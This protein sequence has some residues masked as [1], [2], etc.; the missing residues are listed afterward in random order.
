MTG[1][2]LDYVRGVI[3]SEGF[4][5]A[6]IHYSNFEKVEDPEFHEKRRAFVEAHRELANYLNLEVW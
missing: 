2:E 1:E 5:Y 6:F 4:E 3:Y